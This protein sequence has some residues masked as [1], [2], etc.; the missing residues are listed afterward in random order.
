ME[1]IIPMR[2]SLKSATTSSS[3]PNYNTHTINPKRMKR[4]ILYIRVSTDE[5]ADKGFSL[6]SQ[7]EYLKKY[8]G[9]NG[10][11]I[12][13]TFIE[14]HSAKTFNRPEFKKMMAFCKKNKADID[15]LLFV[16]WDRFSRN[17][18]DSYQMIHEFKKLNIES[19]A[20]EQP[21]DLSV[22]ES[23]I[24]LAIYLASPEVE[25]DRRSLNVFNGMRKAKKEGRYMGSAPL[26]YK[27]TRDENNKPIVAPDKNARFIR[28]A[29]EYMSTGNFTQEEIRQRLRS[30][31]FVCSRNGFNKIL[32]NP[33]Y[34][35]RLFVPAYKD[36]SDCY[37]KGSHEAI[38]DEGLF[39]KVQEL[40]N[41]RKPVN[42]AKNTCREEFPLRG[43]LQCA[44]CGKLL[45]GSSG[46]SKS[47]RRYYYYHCTK[48]CKEI[49]SADKVHAAFD[50]LLRSIVSKKEAMDLHQRILKAFFGQSN[51]ERLLSIQNIQ[52]EIDKNKAR[53]NKAMQMM[54]DG[55]IES[56]EYKGI[57]SRF[58]MA[59]AT[60]LRERASLE[61]DKV[62]YVPKINGCFNLLRELDKFY[63]EASVSV[64]Q[65]IV[66]L[67]FPEKLIYENGRIQTPKMNE[68]LS[69]I[70]LGTNKLEHKKRDKEKNFFTLSPEVSL[71]GF[72]PRL[73]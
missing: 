70:M 67:N 18:K 51:E 65:K 39:L 2:R 40:L 69:L 31:G 64:K 6:A 15:F 48:G 5:Q 54:L 7:E 21:L 34:A 68:V 25:N 52:S 27:N 66:C 13:H 23:K 35:G 49:Y 60:L 38:V 42:T 1:T 8:C 73:F 45:T 59:N 41:Q 44:S 16:K 12:I 33:V 3:S 46:L 14:D 72:K 53:I 50:E 37:I 32:R 4:A 22:P 71:Q 62:D 56:G 61:M 36:E 19:R 55:E 29:F 57:K 58:E 28:Q 20:I 9:V 10:I 63:R 43:Y 26:G 11:E 47:K 17:T 24:M 30:K